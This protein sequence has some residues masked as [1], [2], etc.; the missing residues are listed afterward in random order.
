MR[1]IKRYGKKGGKC[2]H[3]HNKL[4]I[5]LTT[6]LSPAKLTNNIELFDALQQKRTKVCSTRQVVIGSFTQIG[7][8][9]VEMAG[10]RACTSLSHDLKN[11]EKDSLPKPFSLAEVDDVR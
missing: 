3:D 2:F 5:Y 6:N 11:S 7:H 1:K 8:C 9:R 10:A 4:A